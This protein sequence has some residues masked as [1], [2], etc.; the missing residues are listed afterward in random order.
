MSLLNVVG[1]NLIVGSQRR[2]RIWMLGAWVRTANH[3]A[4]ILPATF[5]IPWFPSSNLFSLKH[6]SFL[7]RLFARQRKSLLPA[8]SVQNA[9]RYILAH[10]RS[11]L[12]SVTRPAADKP[13]VLDTRVPVDQKISVPRVF[14]LAN[15]RLYNRRVA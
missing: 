7:H 4:G 9:R 12:E 10:R 11:V 13:N 1:P 15:A 5:I 3:N 14:V 2:R 6:S 8:R